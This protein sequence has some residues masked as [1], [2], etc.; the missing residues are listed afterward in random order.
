MKIEVLGTAET[1]CKTSKIDTSNAE[2]GTIMPRIENT[3]AGENAFKKNSKKVKVETMTEEN[4]VEVAA[5]KNSIADLYAE[6]EKE[7]VV[8]GVTHNTGVT[9]RIRDLVGQ[10]FDSTQKEKLLL[11][12]VVKIVEKQE[13]RTKMYNLVRSIATSKSEHAKYALLTEDG[14]TY[15]VRK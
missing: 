2:R 4:T 7:L 12:A 15:I 11:S 3:N 1:L 13:G 10:I 14:R 5:K 9:V 6:M 8:K